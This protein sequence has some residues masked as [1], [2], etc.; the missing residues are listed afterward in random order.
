MRISEFK[1][2]NNIINIKDE[3]KGLSDAK[4]I[5]NR[6]LKYNG[7]TVDIDIKLTFYCASGKNEIDAE[8]ER[9]FV[10]GIGEIT[11]EDFCGGEYIYI[12]FLLDF[13]E[14]K[15]TL[16]YTEIALI[17]KNPINNFK[18]NLTNDV[19]LQGSEPFHVRNLKLKYDYK[20]SR[21][22]IQDKVPYTILRPDN[23]FPEPALYLFLIPTAE[24]DYNRLEDGNNISGNTLVMLNNGV[25]FLPQSTTFQNGSYSNPQIALP[26]LEGFPIFENVLEDGILFINSDGDTGF[27]LSVKKGRTNLAY[28]RTDE[29]IIIGNSYA[30]PR[31]VLNTRL[32]TNHTIN[33]PFFNMSNMNTIGDYSYSYQN[34]TQFVDYN[35]FPNMLNGI[36]IKKGESLWIVSSLRL[37]GTLWGSFN[38]IDGIAMPAGTNSTWLSYEEIDLKINRSLE[39]E[40]ITNEKAIDIINNTNDA[41]VYGTEIAAFK[42]LDIAPQVFNGLTNSIFQDSCYSDFWVTNGERVRRKQ[43]LKT[44]V[45]KPDNFFEELEKIISC[46]LGVFYNNNIASLQLQSID[47]FYTDTVFLTLNIDNLDDITIEPILSMYYNN[48]EVGYSESQKIELDI[49]NKNIYNIKTKGKSNFQKVS[50][51]IASKYI[52][53]KALNLGTEEI[54]KEYD[55]KIFI[56]SGTT[57][58]GI[59]YTLSQSNGFAADEVIEN[60]IETNGINRRYASV[61]NLFRHFRKWGYSL[62][63][64]YEILENNSIFN[65]NFNK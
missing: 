48:I 60:P 39:I 26:N 20:H 9:A 49:H 44:F 10:D 3:P 58:N 55:N 1:I 62:W 38:L 33:G 6:D 52:I 16:D 43:K 30:N 7:M 40:F 23:L 11:I 29:T 63:K 17:E 65:K 5:F 4:I 31:L 41:I 46:G 51:W 27:E 34:Q 61:Y 21:I 42:G 22:K 50:D 2:N 28:Y 53:K 54:E 12:T 15:S 14:Y 19:E 64:N 59:N 45:V 25:F 18:D 13:K 56:F 47:K 24:V 36:P 57:T 37:R 32:N 8:Y 35:L